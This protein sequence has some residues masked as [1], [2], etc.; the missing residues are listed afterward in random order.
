MK[1]A[2]CLPVLLLLLTS[3]CHVVD[4]AKGC[5]QLSALAKK[6]APAIAA[7]KIP[8]SPSS[9]ALRR[10]AKLYGQLAETLNA[11]AVKDQA[12]K[13]ARAGLITGL[14]SLAEHLVEAAAAVDAQAKFLERQERAAA[15]HEQI[16]AQ[17]LEYAAKSEE[18][19]A[20]PTP[21][22]S[23]QADGKGSRGAGPTVPRI[24]DVMGKGTRGRPGPGGA[25]SPTTPSTNVS[26][27]TYAY[28]RAKRAAEAATR[29]V[30]SGIRNL[31]TACR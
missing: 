22:V 12:V 29:A 14:Q 1:P 26:P 9:D 4:R 3:G 15:R 10:K 27:H 19:P 17:K 5:G 21:P 25:F 28:E 20:G 8:D 7:A 11:A 30:E 24:T 2:W 16:L 23:T 18:L 13:T 31:E 6:A